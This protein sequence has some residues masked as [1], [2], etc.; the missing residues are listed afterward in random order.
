MKMP[1]RRLV[2]RLD[3]R[4]T[5]DRRAVRSARTGRIGSRATALGEGGPIRPRPPLG[6][7]LRAERPDVRHRTAGPDQ[8]LRQ[9]RRRRCPP[10]DLHR[11]EHARRGRGRPDGHRPPSELRL[12]RLPVRVRLPDGR[13]RVAQPGPPLP[14]VGDHADVLALHRP[15]RH[16][17]GPGPQWL[18][19]PVRSRRQA[20]R[21]DGRRRHRLA[22]AGPGLAQRQGPP[23]QR[24]RHDPDRQ[25]DHAG[26]DPADG[27]VLDGPP[28]PAGDRLPPDHEPSLSHGAWSGRR[29]RDQHD[30]LA[31]E[32][33]LAERHRLGRSRASAS[34]IQPGRPV[35]RRSRSAGPPSPARPIGA[36]SATS[37]SP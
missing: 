34:A 27:R 17:S 1:V 22:R 15:A 2:P 20:V 7:C 12:E 32:L 11:S 33:R 9:R 16:A 19:D 18:P 28:E 21:D 6:C 23:A 35:A 30:H 37:C 26:R 29:R 3:T 36:R 10:Q 31:W 25:P 14:R 8:H 5:D 24:Q 13:G 4:R